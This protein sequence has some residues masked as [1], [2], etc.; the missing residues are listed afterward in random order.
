MKTAFSEELSEGKLD[1]CYLPCG[2]R[3]IILTQGLQRVNP[4]EQPLRL[5][6]QATCSSELWSFSAKN[7]G[8]SVIV[9]VV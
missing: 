3:A 1:R 8:Y 4:G 7:G 9:S 2:Y 5:F 6:S